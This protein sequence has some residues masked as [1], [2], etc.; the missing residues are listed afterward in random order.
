MKNTS[1]FFDPSL[2][3]FPS[4]FIK[5]I[6]FFGVAHIENPL[7]ALLLLITSACSLGETTEKS[8]LFPIKPQRK[9]SILL[10]DRVN[11]RL[12]AP[13]RDHGRIGLQHEVED[14]FNRILVVFYPFLQFLDGPRIF[15]FLLN[16]ALIIP[17][18]PKHRVIVLVPP[19]FSH[20]PRPVSS[21]TG[22]CSRTPDSRFSPAV[23]RSFSPVP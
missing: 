9:P 23:P 16:F 13:V 14:P 3:D 18:S 4:T 1:D 17:E 10:R 8:A 11:R 19:P 21:R 2:K 12:I 6:R 7:C 15:L 22:S 20:W 5:L